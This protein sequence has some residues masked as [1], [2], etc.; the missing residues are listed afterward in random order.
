RARRNVDE[1]PERGRGSSATEGRRL[2]RRL[3]VGL[4]NPAERHR[5]TRHNAGFMVVD[6]LASRSG[7]GRGRVE[8]DAW[9]AEARVGDEDVLLVKPLT[10]MNRSGIAEDALLAARGGSPAGV[11]AVVD[12]AALEL[13]EL[14]VRERGSHGGHTGLRSLLQ[15]RWTEEFPPVAGGGRK[16]ELREA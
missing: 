8:A 4:G 5:R 12:D 6:V 9:T 2:N 1:A 3:V 14:R 16:G 10:L 13:G 11:V 7:A 15:A